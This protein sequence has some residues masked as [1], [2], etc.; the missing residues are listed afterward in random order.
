MKKQVIAARYREDCVQLCKILPED[1]ELIIYNKGDKF[2]LPKTVRERAADVRMVRN[3]GREGHT[4]LHHIVNNYEELADVT[5]FTQA[6]TSDHVKPDQLVNYLTIRQNNNPESR[7]QLATV[8]DSLKY[9]GWNPAFKRPPQHIRPA[10]DHPHWGAKKSSLPFASWWEKYVRLPL[11]NPKTVQFSWGGI[12]A[13]NREYIHKY[14]KSY[15]KKLEQSLA[16]GINP[17]EGHFLERAWSYIFK[18][19]VK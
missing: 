9:T 14:S 15:Y 11:P 17:E 3:V 1:V 6:S 18:P 12:F 13:V 4:Y 5:L 8:A 19:G 10:V 16:V 2:D 7:M